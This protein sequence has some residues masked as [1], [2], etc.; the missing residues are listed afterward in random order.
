MRRLPYLRKNRHRFGRFS[1]HVRADAEN[2][3]ILELKRAKLLNTAA[4]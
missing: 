4:A 2:A 1:R 3:A